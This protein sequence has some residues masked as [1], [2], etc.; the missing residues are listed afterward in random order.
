MLAGSA[1]THAGVMS[2]SNIVRVATVS[3]GLVQLSRSEYVTGSSQCGHD[4]PLP[5]DLQKRLHSGH[6]LMPR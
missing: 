5:S 4:P 6:L 2:S 1:K 3:A